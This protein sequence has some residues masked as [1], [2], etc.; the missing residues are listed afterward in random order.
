MESKGGTNKLA[1]VL[2]QRMSKVAQSNIDNVCDFGTI[3][4]D[5][6]LVTN[7]FPKPIPQGSYVVCRQLTLGSRDYEF[8]DTT[9]D[10]GEEKHSHKVKIPDK[11]SSLKAGDR[12]FVCWVQNDAVVV[13]VLG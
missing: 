10:G 3:Q 1:Q 6:S 12:V 8:A 9:E 13:D 11:M 2:Q 7:L 5:M 4:G